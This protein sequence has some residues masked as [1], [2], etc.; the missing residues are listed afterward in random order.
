[1][2]FALLPCMLAC[3]FRGGEVFAEIQLLGAERVEFGLMNF[4][5]YRWA[6]LDAFQEHGKSEEARRIREKLMPLFAAPPVMKVSKS[7]LGFRAGV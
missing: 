5:K 6:S 4:V 2:S 7:F 3:L 1:M